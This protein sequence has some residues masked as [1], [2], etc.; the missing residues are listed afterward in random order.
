MSDVSVIAIQADQSV[1]PTQ[2]NNCCNIKEANI[3]IF[4]DVLNIKYAMNGTGK[5]T[6][7]NALRWAVNQDDDQAKRDELFNTLKPFGSRD[8]P[9]VNCNG[10]WKHIEM[11]N[12]EFLNTFVFKE[13]ETIKDS[14]DVFIRTKDYETEKANIDS[15]ISLLKKDL[16]EN[17]SIKAMITTFTQ[18]LSSL[19]FNSANDKLNQTPFLKSIK[20]PF[21]VY[22]LQENLKKFETF[23]LQT[24]N[25]EWVD[26]KTKGFG[27]DANEICP[28]CTEKLHDNYQTEKDTFKNT[29]SK[30]NVQNLKS[31]L[32]YLR[33]LKDYMN[34]EVYESLEKAIT[35]TKDATDLEFMLTAFALE[36]RQVYTKITVAIDFSTFDIKREQLKELNEILVG[37][38]IDFSQFKYFNS[39]K[40]K[41]VIELINTKI[42]VLLTKINELK[43]EMADFKQHISSAIKDSTNDINNFLSSA[44]INYQLDINLTSEDNSIARLIYKLDKDNSIVVDKIDKRLSW[45]E[46]NAFALILFMFMALSKDA[47][48]IILDDPISSFDSNKKYAIIHRLFHQKTRV[49]SFCKKTVLML[50]HDFEPIIDFKVKKRFKD[51]TIKSWYLKNDN[52]KLVEESINVG[53]DIIPAVLMY[54]E[55]SEDPQLHIINKLVF[56]RKYTEYTCSDVSQDLVYNMLSSLLH[57]RKVPN[58]T[59]GLET[60]VD[61]DPHQIEEATA[62]IEK[63]I[64]GFDY[65]KLFLEFFNNTKNP[66]GSTSEDAKTCKT[67]ILN[68]YR[69]TTPSYLKMQLVRIYLKF[70]DEKVIQDQVMIKFIDESFH[71]D[72]DYTHCLNYR[73]FDLVPTF[74]FERV[75]T[76]MKAQVA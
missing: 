15:R 14:F 47:D 32:D 66:D 61:F 19:K 58:F 68:L 57:L 20:Q 39:E 25:V 59:M 17:E 75:D 72:N 34:Y 49:K 53:E 54:K 48:L 22:N 44:G 28:F 18:V 5:S 29:F 26:W 55:N 27:Y 13:N 56:L 73:K 67:K 62:A 9:S 2:I 71:I 23:M 16:G 7:A 3:T 38:Q 6:I 50:T 63:V 45:G 41:E 70:V 35:Y 51:G 42:D 33:S 76:F 30:A 65:Y 36:L 43:K 52:G 21:N 4:D 10:R 46:K 8:E 11:F 1:R 24:N 40:T 12:E 64:S 69:L 37:R 60:P 74:I 31:M